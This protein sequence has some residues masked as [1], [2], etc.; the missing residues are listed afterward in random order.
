MKTLIFSLLLL[1]F[2]SMAHANGTIVLVV[3]ISNSLNEDDLETQFSSYTNVLR[4]IPYL[5]GV[6]VEVV[7]FE[8]NPRHV[9]S[10]SH[11]AAAQIFED[12]PRT[13]TDERG[14]TCLNQALL[15]VEIMMPDLPPPV[16]ID[17]SGDGD[18][19]CDGYNN[20]SYATLHSTLDRLEAAGATV[21][22]LFMPPSAPPGGGIYAMTDFMEQ[23]RFY[24][25]LRRGDGFSIVAENLMAFEEALFR[26]LSRE[27]AQ[28]R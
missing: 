2:S 19:N 21:N 11:L 3:D 4:G 8:N 6:N 10:G 9:S 13:S 16:V 15:Y 18:A 12:L 23:I 22:T 14:L 24:G 17:I 26:K 25:T 1:V 20:G 27:I 28:L 7:L 5:E